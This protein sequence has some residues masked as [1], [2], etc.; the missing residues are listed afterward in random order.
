MEYL[1]YET[2][3]L[4]NDKIYIGQHKTN[5]REDGYLGSGKLLKSAIEKHGTENFER[6]I[7]KI[8]YNKKDADDIEMFYIAERNSTDLNIGYNIT[9]WAWGGQ[10]HTE[11]TRRKI[12]E[13]NRGKKRTEEQKQKLRKPKSG[14]RTDEHIA[15]YKK[16]VG[17]WLWVCN[18]ETN[19]TIQI[20]ET[21]KI[22]E[23]Y[24]KGRL[25]AGLNAGTIREMS[26]KGRDNIIASNKDLEKRT[27]IANSL[28]GRKL[29]EETK[30]KIAKTLRKRK[31]K[32]NEKIGDCTTS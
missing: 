22:P 11:E 7:L 6:T 5:N 9:K 14:P 23:G 25:N 10:P 13:G 32:Q 12:S 4:A 28:K 20:K 18:K 15:N 1:I 8:C 2:K 27:K 24:I 17:Q 26:S 3:C 21:D 30:A 31:E 16:S 19:E 29:S